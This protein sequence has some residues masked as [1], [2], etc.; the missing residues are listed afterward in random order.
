MKGKLLLV[1]GLLV[2][3][4]SLASA[5]LYNYEITSNTTLTNYQVALNCT[6][7]NITVWH[8]G[9]QIPYYWDADSN[10]TWVKLN[11]T[12]NTPEYID[13]KS[14]TSDTSD[15]TQVFDLFDDFLGT[16]LN[17]S[18]WT[19]YQ[20]DSGASYTISDSKI[21][22]SPTADVSNAVALKSAA[23]FTNDIIVEAKINPQSD[24][25]YDL[26]LI[27]IADVLTDVWHINEDDNLGYS[28]LAQEVT[29]SSYGYYLRRRDSGSY[30]TLDG[31]SGGGQ[32]LQE[33]TYKLIY[34]SSGDLKGYVYFDDGSL[35]TT[36]SATDTAYL[37][38][39]KHVVI[40][41]GEYSD[42]K[43]AP[44]AW[45]WVL[46][47]KYSNAN[48]TVTNYTAGIEIIAPTNS[49]YFAGNQINATVYTS[50]NT[51]IDVYLDNNFIKSVDV[52][53]GDNVFPLNLSSTQNTYNLTVVNSSNSSIY[54]T[55]F[56]TAL[57]SKIA[58]HNFP[59]QMLK[60]QNA[61]I[62]YNVQVVY[63]YSIQ[64]YSLL[65][66]NATTNLLID[67]VNSADYSNDIWSG[68]VVNYNYYTTTYFTQD[69]NTVNFS[70]Y[71]NYSG[72][73]WDN[74]TVNA[75]NFSIAPCS[76]NP[77]ITLK[78]YNESDN[79]HLSSG[80]DYLSV[81]TLFTDHYNQTFSFENKSVGDVSFC[82]SPTWA[83]IQTN[84]TIEYS[85]TNMSLRK[86]WLDNATLTNSTQTVKMYLLPSSDSQL[87]TFSLK[88]K[89]G[90][91]KEGY[92]LQ[93]LKWYADENE[94][95]PVAEVKTDQNGEGGT[96]LKMFDTWYEVLVL[97]NGAVVQRM[98]PMQI[99]DYT[100]DFTY[101][102]GI[103]NIAEQIGDFAYTCSESGGIISCTVA[104]TSGLAEQ[105][106]LEV[107]QQGYF[108]NTLVSNQT[109]TA[110]SGSLIYTLPDSSHD[111]YYSL[112]TVVGGSKYPLTSN[113]VQIPISTEFGQSGVVAAVFLVL[114]MTLAVAGYPTLIFIVLVFTVV[115][116]VILHFLYLTTFGII[117]LIV[118]AGILLFKGRK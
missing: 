60:G 49:T 65:I 78:V 71:D 117:G 77:S 46:V 53:T 58:G 51:T 98:S 112:Y 27:T 107:Y 35:W 74:T 115:M 55:V 42:G 99:L 61:D 101:E 69:I 26:G 10:K 41:Q 63:P 91:S 6:T 39:A 8:G 93:F 90:L 4:G 17:T 56:F 113:V 95:I 38:D 108:T 83:S 111:Y 22:L 1:V 66:N 80:N 33:I 44:S 20:N 28:M 15:G 2:L 70:I 31:P 82:I 118:V 105:W 18:K 11:L 97:Y 94:Y 110:S 9:A 13:I 106:G 59:S 96:Y 103:S 21:T 68:T 25:Y 7:G 87:I 5:D 104:D 52:T 48:I 12:A 45:D 67:Y 43:G 76:T 114:T 14:A 19:E 72:T 30:T 37:S 88:D 24:F 34:T 50:S 100:V 86:W 85:H 32:T 36:L 73:Q 116:S 47:R 64:N 84:A 3:F 79:T 102:E 23:T 81:F 75:S 109:L 29:D 62:S 54:S 89:A 16:S 40:W 57:H 92:V